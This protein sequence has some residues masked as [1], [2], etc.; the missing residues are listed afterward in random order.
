MSKT[1]PVTVQFPVS[2]LKTIAKA[3]GITTDKQFNLLIQSPEFAK[4]LATMLLVSWNDAEEHTF[5]DAEADA[6][7]I[8]GKHIKKYKLTVAPE[9]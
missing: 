8:F 6:W 7:T 2:K 4:R 3:V 5:Y 1:I 9:E